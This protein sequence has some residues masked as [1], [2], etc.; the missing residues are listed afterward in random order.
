MA[1]M[2]R[3]VN[4]KV[5]DDD[6]HEKIGQGVNAIAKIRKNLDYISNEEREA[7]IKVLDEIRDGSLQA[8]RDKIRRI[9]NPQTAWDKAERKAVKISELVNVATTMTQLGLI[10]KKRAEVDLTITSDDIKTFVE[11]I[12]EIKA[13]LQKAI[14]EQKTDPNLDYIST[15]VLELKYGNDIEEMNEENGS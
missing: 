12:Q 3:V 10:F 5:N 2:L 13:Q 6:E 1:D 7:I 11:N 14:E 8:L 9:T 15:K 4:K